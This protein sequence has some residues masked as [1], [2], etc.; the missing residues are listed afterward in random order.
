MTNVQE[1]ILRI[2][3]I[4]NDFLECCK[5]HFRMTINNDHQIPLRERMRVKRESDRET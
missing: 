3:K 5:N 4:Q 2:R 1:R